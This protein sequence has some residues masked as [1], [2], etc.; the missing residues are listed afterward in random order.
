MKKIM[1]NEVW[2]KIELYGR[3]IEFS[4]LGNYRFVDGK[5]HKEKRLDFY[6][7]YIIPIWYNNKL[8]NVSIHRQ[9]ALLFVENPETIKFD[10]VNHK[11]E[12]KTNNSADNLEWC[13]RKYNNNYGTH[14]KRAAQSHSKPIIQYTLDGKFVK[15]WQSATIASK[16]LGYA[17]SAINW[18]CLRKPKY[19]SYKG[20]IWRYKGDENDLE[21]KNGKT[22]IMLSK[23]N[24]F[25]KEFFNI[26]TAVQ[27][28]G[29]SATSISNVLSGRSKTA[30]G[31]KW[32]L[33]R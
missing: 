20:Y 27:E 10:C 14:N 25:I 9:I 24:E 8:H 15:E 12:I 2:K 4:N 30:G 23:D 5:P 1:F 28:T 3:V 32:E 26:K 21:Y 33:K 6:G 16:E 17:Q 11:D 13:D 31:F 18:C 29:V 7:Y 22:I 19:N